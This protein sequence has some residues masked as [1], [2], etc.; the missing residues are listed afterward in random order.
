MS[1]KNGKSCLKKGNLT[2]KWKILLKEGKSHPK[3]ENPSQK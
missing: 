2:P 1:L 3:M